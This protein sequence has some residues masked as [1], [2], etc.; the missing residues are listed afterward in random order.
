MVREKAWRSRVVFI[1]GAL[2][3]IAI[4]VIVRRERLREEANSGRIWS[5]A[6]GHWHD[7]YGM[8]IH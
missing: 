1:G 5:S 8:E 4:A 3:L 7:R 6:H 2:V